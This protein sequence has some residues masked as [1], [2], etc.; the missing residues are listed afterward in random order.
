MYL[1][2]YIKISN[3]KD[4]LEVA[5]DICSFILFIKKFIIYFLIFISIHLYI[6]V[7]INKFL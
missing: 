3:K 7:I 5:S 1:V 6:F 2:Y 4:I